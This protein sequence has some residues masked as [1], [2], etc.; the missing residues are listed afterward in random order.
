MINLPVVKNVCEYN[1]GHYKMHG[2]Y[3]IV[4]LGI[5]GNL[6]TILAISGV[7]MHLLTICLTELVKN[8][9]LPGV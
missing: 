3:I 4:S 8:G 2:T 7:P 5:T 1:P 6:D 9:I